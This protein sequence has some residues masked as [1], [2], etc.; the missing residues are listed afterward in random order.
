MHTISLLFLRENYSTRSHDSTNDNQLSQL[1][2]N[3]YGERS[4][5]ITV[6]RMVSLKSKICVSFITSDKKLVLSF[7]IMKFHLLNIAN[8]YVKIFVNIREGYRLMKELLLDILLHFLCN[9]S[10]CIFLRTLWLATLYFYADH[11][12]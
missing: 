8:I 11:V 10:P 9:M 6:S 2:Y 3:G 12:G 7:I 5:Q 4:V 1:F